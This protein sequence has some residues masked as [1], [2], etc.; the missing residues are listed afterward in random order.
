MLR[1]LTLFSRYVSFC[2]ICLP[3][4]DLALQVA[5]SSY[6]RHPGVSPLRVRP[7]SVRRPGNPVAV[8]NPHCT[9]LSNQALPG[10]VQVE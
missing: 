5:N 10:L 1:L 9:F 7:S 2:V 8:G 3:V 6:A 4:C